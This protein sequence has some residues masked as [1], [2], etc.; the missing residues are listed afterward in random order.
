MASGN[1]NGVARP[2]ANTYVGIS[3]VSRRVQRT[4][5][6]VNNVVRTVNKSYIGLE[7]PVLEIQAVFTDCYIFTG[8]TSGEQGSLSWCGNAETAAQHGSYSISSDGKSF[9]ARAPYAGKGIYFD[10][11]VKAVCG[12]G[13]VKDFTRV[14]GIQSMSIPITLSSSGGGEWRGW[15]GGAFFDVNNLWEVGSKTFTEMPANN[16]LNIQA[17]LAYGSYHT[18]T[19]T[20]GRAQINGYEVPIKFVFDVF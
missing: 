14:Q 6:G 1:V 17:S 2:V 3:G 5:A 9:S 11:N 13:T 19:M 16:S 20:L 12:D 18:V 15:W 10:G 7:A 4:C 8:V